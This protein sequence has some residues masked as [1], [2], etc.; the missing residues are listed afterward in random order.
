MAAIDKYYENR[1]KINTGDLLLWHSNDS[2][3]GWA[4]HRYSF[5]NHA[6]LAMTFP[7]YDDGNRY[8]VEAVNTVR[9]RRL[10]EKLKKYHGELWLFPL[11]PEFDKYRKSMGCIALGWEGLP[12]DYKSLLG[13]LFG[14]VDA[15]LK[16]LFCSE[17][18]F[19]A[20]KRA[21]IYKLEKIKKAPR[22]DGLLKLGVWGDGFNLYRRS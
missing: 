17:L 9:I 5:F 12:Y 16:K 7:T 22:P 8:T 15:D 6:S 13:N 18:V 19:L 4:I 20:A 2:A 21:G 3:L 11:I 10:S 1:H 14:L